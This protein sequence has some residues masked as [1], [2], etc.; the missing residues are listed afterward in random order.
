MFRES[1]RK[2]AKDNQI[3]GSSTDGIRDMGFKTSE[4]FECSEDLDASSNIFKDIQKDLDDLKANR[5]NIAGS[6]RKM[7]YIW[8]IL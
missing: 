5:S 4:S 2:L 3:S 1:L 6:T 8:F 7:V